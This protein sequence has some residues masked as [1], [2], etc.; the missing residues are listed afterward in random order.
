MTKIESID[1]I[2]FEIP[3]FSPL[4]MKAGDLLAA[5]HALVRVHLDS[6]VTGVSEAPER[7]MF[8]GETLASI[9]AAVRQIIS[10]LLEQDAT[11]T[12]NSV[13]STLRS[14][15][16]NHTAV[17]AVEMAFADALARQ[18]DCTVAQLLGGSDHPMRVTHMIGAGDTNAMRDEAQEA[19]AK[20]I[21]AFKVKIGYG[22]DHDMAAVRSV[23]D[24]IGRDSL[25]YVDGNLAYTAEDSHALLSRMRDEI[26][27]AWAEEPYNPSPLDLDN[28]PRTPVP[29]M[30]DE[31]ATDR[32][33]AGRQL[34]SGRARK[35]SVK[36]ARTGFQRS[37]EIATLARHFGAEPVL[38]SQGDGVMGTLSGL[39]FASS[40]GDDFNPFGELS[41]FTRLKDD[42]TV[43]T[44]A[45]TNGRISHSGRPGIGTNID[46]DKLK[47]YR[48][49][50]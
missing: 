31:T 44:P 35:I 11:H 19:H 28:P 4:R 21:R 34:L 1:C 38:G 17:A 23:R 39:S 43:D 42:I 30:V 50:Q 33:S 32:D 37:A 16:A 6:G 22:S 48:L 13:N 25:L 46:E 14:V 8:Y 47:H 24:G 9:T 41:Y 20:G 40:Y 5:R 36:V 3:Y 2:P 49:D 18:A 12:R 29:I 27:L 26:D 7:P 45:I 10:P 15:K